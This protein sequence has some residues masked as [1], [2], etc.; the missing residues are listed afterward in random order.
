MKNITDEKTENHTE[1]KR[2]QGEKLKG[3]SDGDRNA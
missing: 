3:S 2:N 1:D